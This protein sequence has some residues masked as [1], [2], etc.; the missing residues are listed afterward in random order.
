MLLVEKTSQG[1]LTLVDMLGTNAQEGRLHIR[2]GKTLAVHY[3]IEPRLSMFADD[4]D[5]GGV[6]RK[7]GIAPWPPL[8]C[9]HTGRAKYWTDSVQHAAARR[10]MSMYAP[11]PAR[12][13]P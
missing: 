11:G 4:R 7:A 12:E 9:R 3:R 1:V 2:L 13:A 5:G 6:G 8:H 10:P